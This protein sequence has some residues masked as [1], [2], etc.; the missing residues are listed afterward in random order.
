MRPVF[1]YKP[2][3]QTDA[4]LRWWFNV[5][6]PVFLAVVVIGFESTNLCS[7]ANTS[8]LLRP[9]LERLFGHMQNSSW[10]SLHHYLRKNGHFVGYGTVGF[11]FLR[12]WLYTLARSEPISLTSWR[13]KSCLF[14]ILSTAFIASCDEFHQT[15]IPSRT[16]SPLDVLLDSAGACALCLLV[17][18]VCWSKRSQS[19]LVAREEF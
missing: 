10:D 3:L 18:L 2:T 15:F 14:A 13:L 8:S 9:I 12:A 6:T 1:I 16:G 7:S 4:N 5:W 11:T 17:W 19:P